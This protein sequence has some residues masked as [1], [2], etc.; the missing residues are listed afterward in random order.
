[1]Y[2]ENKCFILKNMAARGRSQF[3]L[4]VYREK[5][6]YSSNDI[7]SETAD[8][9]LMKL[10]Q[11]HPWVMGNKRYRT[12]FLFW[13]LSGYHGNQKKNLKNSNISST[14]CQNSILFGQNDHQVT[15]NMYAE[16]KCFILK[17]MAARGQ[18]QFFLYVYREKSMFSSKD[19]SS[20]TAG[21]NLMKLYQKHPWVMGNK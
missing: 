8:Q 17:N 5:S 12:E 4:Y 18:R 19:I 11:K 21:Q 2:A 3:S 14:N 20:E 1:M 10:Y 9:N 6:M 13:H 16:S 15:L 7:S